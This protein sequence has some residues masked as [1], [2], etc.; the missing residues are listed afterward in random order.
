MNDHTRLTAAAL[1]WTALMMAP[2]K[3]AESTD[4]V[5]EL[6]QK[7]PYVAV[8]KSDGM[9]HWVREDSTESYRV[10]TGQR[11]GEKQRHGDKKTPEGEYHVCAKYPSDKY[12]YF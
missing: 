2:A 9:L 4:T 5:T 11:D 3:C 1:F 7:K 12:R 6:R 10:G 8:D